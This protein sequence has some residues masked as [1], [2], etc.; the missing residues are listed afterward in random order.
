MS[1]ST[2]KHLN[3]EHLFIAD[4]LDDKTRSSKEEDEADAGAQEA[5]IPATEWTAQCQ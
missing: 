2:C 1:W 5:L 3:P 4:N